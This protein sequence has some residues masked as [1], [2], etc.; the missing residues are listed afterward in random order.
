[1]CLIENG[2][3][4]RMIRHTGVCGR[5]WISSGSAC[6]YYKGHG[7][8]RVLTGGERETRSICCR[9]RVQEG[10]DTFA[11]WMRGVA[12]MRCDSHR[13]ILELCMREDGMERAHEFVSVRH[14]C[15]DVPKK[16]DPSNCG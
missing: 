9:P 15:R 14:P 2:V 11:A 16:L 12:H 6:R 5:C 10:A 4:I 13:W 1:M 8:A 7:C 3:R